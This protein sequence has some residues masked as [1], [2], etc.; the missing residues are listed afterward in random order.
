MG[1]KWIVKKSHHYGGISVLLP[2]QIDQEFEIRLKD[3]PRVIPERTTNFE[4]IR[5]IGN[6]AV[7]QKG[8]NGQP[9]QI[10]D[11]PIELRISYNSDDLAKVEGHVDQLKLAYWDL[12]QWVIISDP[13]HEYQ[14]LPSSTAQIAE[15]RIWTWAGD[16]TLAWGK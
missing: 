15:A 10:F 1:Q 14:I 8:N 13:S 5:I 9:L 2:E 4:L 6:I 16:P 7:F 12:E 3:L 11:P